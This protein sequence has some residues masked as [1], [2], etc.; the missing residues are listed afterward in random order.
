MIC[1]PVSAATSMFLSLGLWLTLTFVVP[2]GLIQT[3]Q[4]DAPTPSRLQSIVAI[5][6]A[7]HEAEN[8][9]QALAES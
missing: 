2:T 5:R 4:Q 7:Q 8:N 9:E 6:E 3:A 1:N